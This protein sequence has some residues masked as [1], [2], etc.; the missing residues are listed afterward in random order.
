MAYQKTPDLVI[1]KSTASADSWHTYWKLLGKDYY[2]NLNG[3]SPKAS[4]DQFGSQE[5]NSHSFY[6]KTSTGSGANKSGGMIYYAWHSVEG[7]SK[8]GEYTA[9]NSAS[10]PFVYCGF[11]PK[12]VLIW[13]H[14]GSE[15][16]S[17]YDTERSPSNF[18]GFYLRLGENNTE[19]TSN[20]ESFA[21]DIVSNGFK[22]R[23]QWGSINN[24]NTTDKYLFAAWAE[25]PF[26]SNCRAR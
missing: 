7:F 17:I 6:V 15:A 18:N 1:C 12:V 10:G 9:N 24:T 14:T 8:F 4:S 22:P 13:C 26:S 23:G 19:P 3:T 20:T 5:A 11:Q 25:H 21:I 2:I 16:R